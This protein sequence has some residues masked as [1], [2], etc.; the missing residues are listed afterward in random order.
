VTNERAFVVRCAQRLW[1][2][3]PLLVVVLEGL[4]QRWERRPLLGTYGE[5]SVRYREPVPRWRRRRVVPTPET[6]EPTKTDS[7]RAPGPASAAAE[8]D[9]HDMPIADAE[10]V[11][12]APSPNETESATDT[13]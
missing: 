1:L 4:A 5:R 6:S 13:P 2:T 10:M 9:G 7:E 11:T 12:N 3:L 8:T